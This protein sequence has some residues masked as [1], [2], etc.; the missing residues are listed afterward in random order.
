MNAGNR[1]GGPANRGSTAAPLALQPG[2]R[3]ASV[4]QQST[5]VALQVKSVLGEQ[6]AARKA[7]A[8]EAERARR[9]VPTVDPGWLGSSFDLAQGLDVKVM[10]SKLSPE[11]LEELFRSS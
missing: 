7:R 8:A 5:E 9:V 4:G 3:R 6:S 2:S 1:S 10:D 11:T